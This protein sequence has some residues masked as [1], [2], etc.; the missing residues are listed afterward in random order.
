MKNTL[1][2]T[3]FISIIFIANLTFAQ[4]WQP[5]KSKDETSKLSLYKNFANIELI[6]IKVPTIVEFAIDASALQTSLDVFNNT[7]KEFVYSSFTSQYKASPHINSIIDS[8]GKT[9]LSKLYDRNLM[10]SEDYYLNGNSGRVTF[11]IYFNLPLTTSSLTLSLDKNVNLP[12]SVTVTTLKDGKYITLLNNYR[13]SSSVIVF[14]QTTS[15]EFVVSLAYS[16]PLRIT[17][18]TFN[19]SISKVSNSL[20]RFLALPNN[21][22]SIYANPEKYISSFTG[23]SIPN[24]YQSSSVKNIGSF[25]LI[26]NPLFTPA[27][28]DKDGIPDSRDNCLNIPN[29]SQADTDKN[30][31]GNECDD[32]DHDGVVNNVDNCIN[33]PNYDQRDTDLDKVGDICDPDESRLTQKYPFIVWVSLIVAGLVFIGL[34]VVV[35]KRIKDGGSTPTPT[36]PTPDL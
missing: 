6:D 15:S 35:V 20:V 3:I 13:P 34:L 22:Y 2:I 12:T 18:I 30:G 31:V 5:V 25:N 1:K 29:G 26:V 4:D 9:S 21:T 28:T 17:E 19:D 23:N 33:I 36:P 7:T 27:D 24:L 11:T 16:Q 10:T 32:Y 8:L 14:P